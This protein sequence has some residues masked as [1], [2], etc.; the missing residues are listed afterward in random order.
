MEN[1]S[2]A[3]KM[4]GAAILFVLAFSVAMVMF[5]KVRQTTDAIL[6]NLRIDEFY[7]K[8]EPLDNNVT[9]VVGL[10]TVIPT[11]YRYA[12]SDASIRIRILADDGTEH[13]V[14]D[15]NL[16][17]EVSEA[18][19]ITPGSSKDT[20]YYQKLREKYNNEGGAVKFAYLF[21]AP[22]R[23]QSDNN[24]TYKVERINAYI[25]GTKMQHMKEVAY[26]GNC[27]EN[28]NNEGLLGLI[29]QEKRDYPGANILFEESYIEYNIS[30]TVEKDEYDEEIVTKPPGTKIIITYK[31][32]AKY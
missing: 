21:Q 1:A 23:N 30:G 25:Y 9:R 2:D 32:V 20:P 5:T 19:T 18:A 28:N 24:D 16:D 14:F 7:A 12:Q 6:D 4:A 3:L 26:D 13:Q 27:E 29:D 31:I 8:V 17:A 11:L 15:Q 10:E 22:W